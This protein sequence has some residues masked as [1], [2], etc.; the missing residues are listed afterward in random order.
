MNRGQCANLDILKLEESLRS[1]ARSVRVEFPGAL[2][3]VMARGNRREPIF[4]D[5]EDAKQFVKALGEVCA[6]TGWRVPCVGAA[7]QSLSPHDRDAGSQSGR[8]LLDGGFQM[9]SYLNI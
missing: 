9:G 4:L 2:Y 7:E 3:H 1:I 6:M 5:K 8:R